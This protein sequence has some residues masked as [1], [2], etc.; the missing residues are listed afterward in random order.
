[1]D[2]LLDTPEEKRDEK[3]LSLQRMCI[4]AAEKG[5][6]NSR[7]LI[8]VSVPGYISLIQLFDPDKLGFSILCDPE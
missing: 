4:C 7:G 8:R 5:H 6:E 3:A 1:M 2:L